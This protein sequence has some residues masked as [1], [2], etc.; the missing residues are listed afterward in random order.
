MSFQSRVFLAGWTS[1]VLAWACTVANAAETDRSYSRSAGPDT[2]TDRAAEPRAPAETMPAQAIETRRTNVSTGIVRAVE[3]ELD[4]DALISL[5]DVRV[6]N[7]NGIVTLTGTVPSLLAKERAGHLAE[8][9]KGVLDVRNEITVVPKSKRSSDDLESA[10]RHALVMNPATEGFEVQI[11][12]EP[13]G[14]VMLTGEVDSWAERELVGRVAKGI[15]GVT[16][17]KNDLEFNLRK[18]R[19]D[20]EIAAEVERLLRWDVYVDD[21]RIDV[22]V[23]DR[24]VRLLG[25]VPSAA[26][27]RRATAVARVSGTKWVDASALDVKPKGSSGEANS[28]ASKSQGAAVK[29]S[30]AKQGEPRSDMYIAQAVRGAIEADPVARR[31]DQLDVRVVGGVVTLY[32]NVGSLKTQR[33]A[34]ARAA[35]TAGVTDVQNRLRV[36]DAKAAKDEQIARNVIAALAVHPVTEA[37]K[38]SVGV[39]RGVVT[40]TGHVDNWYER[41]TADDVAATVRGVREVNNRLEVTNLTSQLTYDPYVDTWSIEDHDW[42][43]PSIGSTR[44]PDATIVEE[45]REELAWSPFVDADEINVSVVDGVAT[46]SGKVDSMAERR[47]AAENAYEGGA[48]RVENRLQVE[49]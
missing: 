46:L 37:Y 11:E 6:R 35:A 24:V 1:V 33:A 42:Y 20:N 7:Q 40:L 30:T 4:H 18:D 39:E 25:S 45:I 32:G 36:T 5:D 48:T 9:V 17:L 13:N 14:N 22:D 26:E 15:S 12:A 34:V 47:A 31:T 43:V 27:R 23:R 8:T 41:G 44:K 21:S 16:A 2:Y 29:E 38:V 10:I 28:K 19:T 3:E 49:G